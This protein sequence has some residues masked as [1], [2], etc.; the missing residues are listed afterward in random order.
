MTSNVNADNRPYSFENL[1]Q[2]V[3]SPDFAPTI[4]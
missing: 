4:H 1:R 2:Q 3:M